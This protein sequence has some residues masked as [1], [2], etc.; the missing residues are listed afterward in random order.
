MVFVIL[1]TQDKTFERLLEYI[2]K[3][4]KLGN[5]KG[6]VVVQAGQT[7]YESKNMKIL[8]LIPMA[9]FK[10]YI[11]SCDYIITHGGVGS[12]LDGLNAS[13]KIIAVPRLAKYGEHVNDHQVQII[14]EFASKGYIL[15]CN[16]LDKLGDVISKL[17]DFKPK[18]YESNNKNFVKLLT[19][20]IDQI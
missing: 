2:D 15:S 18:K 20:Y 3:N 11:E 1:G 13:K 8:Q 10:K 5:I 9:E 19:D 7:K 4:V 16:D 12:I 6:E 14:D 17:K